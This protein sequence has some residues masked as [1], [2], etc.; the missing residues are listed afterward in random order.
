[1]K[2]DKSQDFRFRM[3][4]DGPPTYLQEDIQDR[5]VKRQGKRTTLL[6]IL[7]PCLLG[8]LFFWG[9][10]DLKKGFS[11]LQDTDVIVSR[12]LSEA[13]NSKFSSISIQ[14][15]KLEESMGTIQDSFTK[16]DAA[17]NE[18][19]IPLNEI[20]LVFEKTTT[21]LKNN[22]KATENAV[23]RLKASKSDRS[24][25]T[26]AIG[27]IDKKISP[28]YQHLKNMEAE[29]KALDENLTQELAE[30]SGT[31]YKVKNGLKQF[32]Q[33]QQELNKISSLRKDISTIASTQ[34]KQIDKKA[35]DK[36]L[37]DQQKRMNKELK[38]VN[39]TLKESSDKIKALEGHVQ[40]LMKFKALSEIKKRLEPQSSS[41]LTKKGA[42]AP[43]LADKK[44]PSKQ[45]AATSPTDT[46][47]NPAPKSGKIIEETLR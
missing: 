4:S 46:A 33:I 16:L 25:V 43:K 12:E 8:I 15:A 9:Y 38:I 23:D 17:F 11:N 32:D 29:I 35:L 40:E 14:V 1:M 24:E 20:Y 36:A 18:K 37:Q 28:V 10:Q 26:E 45:P 44:T 34:S 19:V 21:A 22:L 47:K 39:A 13:L 5:R 3:N 30:L 27:N 41:S 2:T 31:V 42:T 6:T 7:L